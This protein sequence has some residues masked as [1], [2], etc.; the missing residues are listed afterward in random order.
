MKIREATISDAYGIAKVQVD[1]WRTTYVNI[2]PD[3]YL[4]NMSYDKR[5]DIWANIIQTKN[6]YVAENDAG[7]IVGFAS[8]G[9]AINGEYENYPGELT[10]I[11]ILQE[12]QGRGI[13]RL[14]VKEVT[15]TIEKLGY[16][17]MIIFVLKDN[18]AKYFYE[19]LGGKAIDE[20]EI[21]IGDKPLKE[22][23]YAWDDIRLINS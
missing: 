20:V 6:V 19:S 11:Y 10:A 17:S 22:I 9:K 14:L 15:R 12:Y 21:T 4:A 2:V 8:G 18:Q 5:K 3:D 13:G 16:Q 7:E 1:T 23:V